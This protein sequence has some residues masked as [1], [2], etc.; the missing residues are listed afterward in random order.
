MNIAAKLVFAA[1]VTL[2]LTSLSLWLCQVITGASE[3][4]WS[5][6]LNSSFNDLAGLAVLLSLTVILVYDTVSIF[7]FR[8][9]F[10]QVNSEIE[11]YGGPEGVAGRK[12][13][14]REKLTILYP[15][16]LLSIQFVVAMI[17]KHSAIGP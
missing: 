16:F 13:S 6:L 1:L 5:F 17:Y 12:L 3:S 8:F 2:G 9:G 10:E 15:I 4:P 11:F 7:L 14:T